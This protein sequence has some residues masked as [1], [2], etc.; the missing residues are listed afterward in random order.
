MGLSMT[1][2]TYLSKN[3]YLKDGNVKLL[4]IG[5]LNLLGA[6]EGEI[7][8]FIELYRIKNSSENIQQAA[9]RLSY[10]STPRPRERTT[11]L[12]EL[13][14]LTTIE[15]T[16][17]D[18]CPA[19]KTELIDLNFEPLPD[20]HH[21][22]Y[23]IVLNFGTTEHIINQ[24]NCFKVIHESAKIGGIFYHQVPSLG[25]FNHGY[26]TYHELFFKDIAEINGYEIMDI[27]Y[28]AA[29]V[30]VLKGELRPVSDFDSQGGEKFVHKSPC[31]NINVVMRKKTNSQFKLPL[32]LRTSHS[33]KASEIT[34]QQGYSSSE[35][36]VKYIHLSP[37]D[38]LKYITARKLLKEVFAR[39]KN[40]IFKFC[41]HK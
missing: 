20:K 8:D 10:F 30:S 13:L 9:E 12:S 33:A 24:Y 39:L 38:T 31:Y 15:Y 25:W 36:N 32:E 3:G 41:T 37:N 11:Y 34:T 29:T 2:M 18:V 4:D 26:Y 27:W 22:Q 5:S 17:F 1:T 21:E 40:R 6:D 28:M 35:G 19:L 14:D 7:I 23:D 16:S